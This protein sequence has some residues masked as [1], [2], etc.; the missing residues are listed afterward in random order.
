MS[1]K[2]KE[3]GFAIVQ[4]FILLMRIP[5]TERNRKLCPKFFAALKFKMEILRNMIIKIIINVHG[6]LQNL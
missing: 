3:S 5:K 4:Q 6:K 2:H 1:F